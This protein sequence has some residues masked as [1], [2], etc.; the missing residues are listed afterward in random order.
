MKKNQEREKRY[1]RRTRQIC[2]FLVL[3]LAANVLLAGCAGTMPAEDAPGESEVRTLGLAPVFEYEVPTERPSVLTNQAGYLKESRKIAVFQGKELPERFEVID[4]E[5][6]LCVYR[7]TVDY[8]D[9]DAVNGLLTGQGNFTDLQE[10]GNYYIRCDKIGCSYYFTIGDDIYLETAKELQEILE[11]EKGE[12]DSA[13]TCEI[14]SYLLMAYELYPELFVELWRP[15]NT[16]EE[17]KELAGSTAFFEMLRYETDWLLAM[18]D[19]KTGGIYGGIKALPAVAVD[20]DDTEEPLLLQEISE[21][22]TAYF[23]GAMAKYSYF[24]QEYDLEYATICLKAAA[25]AWRYLERHPVQ[26][27]AGISGRF[28][29]ATELYRASNETRYHNYIL[30]NQES[31]LDREE[32]FYFL[33]G[34]VTYLSTRR[35]VNNN[36]CGLMMERLMREAEQISEETKG[37]L[38]LVGDEDLDAIMWNMTVMSVV[39]YAITNHEY[40]TVIEEHVHYLLGRNR[41]AE[42]M[43]DDLGVKDAVGMLLMLSTVLSEKD[44][45][46]E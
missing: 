14:I 36:L 46:G 13:E 19:E 38:F 32:D 6:E 1:T 11:A 33:M 24:Y 18:Q 40:S 27:E 30:Q 25:K 12:R 15:D 35:K 20:I 9:R 37:S 31:L 2:F 42:P 8:K 3:F 43:T 34:E 44:V 17:E 41:W 7:G 26:E 45:A 5:S 10:E 29:A 23:A 39:D 16:V 22:A 4:K 28:Y 21:E